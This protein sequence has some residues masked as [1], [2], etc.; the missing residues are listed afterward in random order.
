MQITSAYP[1][2]INGRR[3][4]TRDSTKNMYG[5]VLLHEYCCTIQS[6]VVECNVTFWRTVLYCTVLYCA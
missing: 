1:A 3:T 5:Y 6:T 2:E 4:S